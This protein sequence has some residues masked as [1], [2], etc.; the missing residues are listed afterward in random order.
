MTEAATSAQQEEGSGDLFGRGMVYVVVWSM[1]MIIATVVSPILAHTLPL[2]EFGALAA[3]IALYQLLIVVTVLGLDQ[4]L[5][6]QRVNDR[7]AT[8]SRGLLA[9]GI[10]FAFAV[11]TILALT[12][13]WWGPALGFGDTTL[14]G[15]PIGGGLVFVTLLWT[16][17]GASVLLVLSMLQAEDRLAR[18]AIISILS[19][20]GGLAFGLGLLFLVE[21]SALGYAWGGVIAQFAALGLGLIWTR[22]R[23]TGDMVTVRRAVALGVPLALASLAQFVLA[24]GDRFA[25]QRMLGEAETARF[26]VAFTVG[27]VLTLLLTFTNR[28]WLPRLKR[29]VDVGERWRTI[30]QARDGIHLLLGWAILGVTLGSPVLLRIFAPASYRPDDLLVVVLVVG[31]CAVPVASSAASG[32]LL[33]TVGRS[34]PLGV[35]AGVAVVVKVVLT[36]ALLPPAGLVGAAVATLAALVAQ[37]G[38]L[39]WSASRTRAA[40]LPDP[41]VWVFL[42]V[43]IVVAWCSLLL[44]TDLPWL[45]GRFTAGLLLLIPFA[46]AFLRLRNG[47]PPF[48]VRQSGTDSVDNSAG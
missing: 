38:Y 39:V 31:L 17:P 8:R 3:A 7:S 16:A 36:V 47:Q 43:V 9:A 33:I 30:Q 46:R 15:L 34:I 35:A 6:M 4:A 24:A 45:I 37:A 40:E 27:N 20:V 44:P 2:E 18:F 5:E 25:I 1:Q 19:T 42:A 41:R 23:W 22:P 12:S 13:Q 14:P 48:G 28:A 11:T 32:Q 29:I 10:V 21:R 26:Q